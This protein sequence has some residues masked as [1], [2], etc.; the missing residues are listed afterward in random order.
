[1]NGSW[2][3]VLDRP[4]IAWICSIRVVYLPQKPALRIF[5]GANVFF[6]LNE[7][8][9][10]FCRPLDNFIEQ[11]AQTPTPTN[12]VWSRRLKM[13]GY[14]IFNRPEAVSAHFFLKKEGNKSGIPSEKVVLEGAR[15]SNDTPVPAFAKWNQPFFGQL[16][17]GL[18]QGIGYQRVGGNNTFLYE[19]GEL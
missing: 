4:S 6:K 7:P 8:T 3:R 10:F 14:D 17:F 1:M 9:D 18:H 5:T 15:L 13:S 19:C 16:A 2:L 11:M 12:Y